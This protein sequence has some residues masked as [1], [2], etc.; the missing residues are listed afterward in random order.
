[1]LNKT[2]IGQNSILLTFMSGE[3]LEMCSQGQNFIYKGEFF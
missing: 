1:M 2:A 3:V